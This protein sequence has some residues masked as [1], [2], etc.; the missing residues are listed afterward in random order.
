MGLT[1]GLTRAGDITYLLDAI[2]DELTQR[3]AKKVADVI[4]S[5]ATSNEIASAFRAARGTLTYDCDQLVA[6]A[7]LSEGE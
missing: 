4:E 1:M 7:R 6:G 2:F 5:G 3:A